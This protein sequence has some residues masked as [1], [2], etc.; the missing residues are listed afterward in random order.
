MFSDA[1]TAER[2]NLHGLL[3]VS[4]AFENR[5]KVARAST[6]AAYVAADETGPNV[7]VSGGLTRAQ[8]AFSTSARPVG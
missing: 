5:T 3:L 8:R 2:M 6:S 7:E 4:I 1:R